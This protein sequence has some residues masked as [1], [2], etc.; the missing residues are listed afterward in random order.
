LTLAFYITNDAEILGVIDVRF[1]RNG[2]GS[3]PQGPHG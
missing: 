2:H 1:G 3:R